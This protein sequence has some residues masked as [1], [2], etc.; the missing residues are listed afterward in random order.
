MEERG[1]AT[2]TNIALCENPDTRSFEKISRWR[3][4]A[5][6]KRAAKAR[7]QYGTVLPS[8]YQRVPTRRSNMGR[9]PSNLNT[10]RMKLMVKTPCDT[11]GSLWRGI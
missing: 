2:R 4:S 6:T 3:R 11:I 10:G 5:R 7:R 8:K 1:A 9:L